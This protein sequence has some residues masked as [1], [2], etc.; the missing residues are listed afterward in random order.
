MVFYRQL[1]QYKR[2]KRDS[3]SYLLASSNWL[4]SVL[5]SREAIAVAKARLR[6]ED[7]ILKDL[8]LT[9]GA[10]LEKDGHYAVAAKW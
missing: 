6:P 8:Y 3:L 9:W 1:E 5:A 7:P 10:I 2:Y 4:L